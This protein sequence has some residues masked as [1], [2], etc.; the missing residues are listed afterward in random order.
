MCK[1]NG[2]FIYRVSCINQNQLQEILTSQSWQMEINA[3]IG[4]SRFKSKARTHDFVQ[5]YFIGSKL[6]QSMQ[7]QGKHINHSD[8]ISSKTLDTIKCVISFSTNT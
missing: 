1:S 2:K 4:V 6:V 5:Q 3:V 7:S 8:Y